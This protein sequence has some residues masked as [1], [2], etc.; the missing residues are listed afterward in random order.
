M[1]KKRV[2]VE[3]CRAGSEAIQLNVVAW[4][5]QLIEG[6]DQEVPI[7]EM[8]LSFPPG[9]KPVDMLDRVREAGEQ[10]AEAAT[11]A[12]EIREELNKELQEEV[13]S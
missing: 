1:V 7:G 13:T 4:E 2:S 6:K 3:S 9:T 10:I 12:K 8:S 11:N 5:M